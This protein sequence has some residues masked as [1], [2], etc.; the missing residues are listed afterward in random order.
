MLKPSEPEDLAHSISSSLF[1]WFSS[2]L[3]WTRN[4]L[5]DPSLA[6]PTTTGALQAQT[7]SLRAMFPF[8]TV[9]IASSYLGQIIRDVLPFWRAMTLPK[10]K[11]LIQ[12]KSQVWQLE[13]LNSVFFHLI[14]ST[15]H[16]S[17]LA[18]AALKGGGGNEKINSPC[19][20]DGIT[21]SSWLAPTEFLL[22]GHLHYYC[23]VSDDE[24][25]ADVL[26]SETPPLL[27]GSSSV[28]PTTIKRDMQTETELQKGC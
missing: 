26:A 19:C 20:W 23:S 17:S 16:S 18:T 24:T 10:L 4:M 14:P 7:Q 25:G 11:C 21:P 28:L 12:Q 5:Y 27:Y 2:Y 22:Q 1:L 6:Y 3:F 9:R 15:A 8:C 13:C